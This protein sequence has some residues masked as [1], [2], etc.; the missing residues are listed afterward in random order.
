[1]PGKKVLFVYSRGGAPL[2]Y[3]FPKIA[4]KAELHVL[5]LKPP[6]THTEPLWSPH[7]TSVTPHWETERTGDDLVGLIVEEAERIGADAILTLSEYAVIA[8]AEAAERL[9]LRGAG[10]NAVNS[11]DKR[12]MRQV[13]EDAGV[14]VPRFRS[15]DSAADLR[16]A[17]R[18]LEA[19]MLLKH[20]WGA[21]AIGQLVLETEADIESAWAQANEAMI[22]ARERGYTEMQVAG[23][24]ADFLV[25]EIIQASTESWWDADSGYGDYLSVEGV[26][27]GGVYHPVCITSRI[28]TIP[29]FTELSNLA[30]CALPEAAQ[31]EIERV[32]RAAVDALGL[33]YCGTHTELKLCPD[34]KLSVLES[35]ARLGGVMVAAEI[36]HCFGVDIVGMLTD[37][38]LGE[39]IDPPERMLLDTDAT[40]AAGSLSLIATDSAGRPWTEHPVWDESLVDWT[41]VVDPGTTVTAVPGLCIP[42][43]TPMPAYD[44]S[45]GALGYG[46][47]FMLRAASA[48]TLVADSYHVLDN[49]EA[50]LAKG[51]E[52]RRTDA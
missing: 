9:G 20:A 41:G 31:R 34:G 12:R 45:T 22:R 43:G 47:I 52:S 1:M 32:S 50:L 39:P 3:A 49:L 46:G 48:D 51:H 8:V 7:C 4:A 18:E 15:V 42:A 26:V 5:A 29:P 13:W 2:E 6:P 23:A 11:R 16:K 19:P 44:L 27:A 28:P 24:D 25:E 36:E 17:F 38:L 30:P 14:P 35:A 10:P 37:A 21:G 40:G 33:D